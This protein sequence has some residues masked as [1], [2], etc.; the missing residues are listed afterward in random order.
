MT[1]L[2]IRPED[3]LRR[4][5]LPADLFARENAKIEVEAYFR[6]WRG[7]D[8]EAGNVVLPLRL[9]Q[10][11]STE[12]FH[13]LIFAALCSPNLSVAVRRISEY[14]RLVAPMHVIVDEDD[15]QLF[16]GIDWDDLAGDPP[17]SLDM[18]ELVFQ[19]QIARI[20]T[21]EHLVPL[22]VE[23]RHPIEHAQE[24]EEFFG[25]APVHGTRH[26]VTFSAADAQRP[27]L[28]ASESM[29]QTFAPE[30]QRRL[31]TLEAEAPLAAR[32]RSQLLESLPSGEA[33]VEVVARRLGLS[34]RTLQRRLTN[35]G[36]SFKEIVR[37]T[38][39]RL[40]RHYVANTKLGYAEIAFLIGFEE[41][42]SFFRAFHDW[43]GQTPRQMRRATVH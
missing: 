11:V 17:A 27:F 19:T 39:E 38:R 28:T 18:T 21:R 37:H 6:L 32:V 14:K 13:P 31:T 1:D 41:P 16:V 34:A 9:G 3:V 29:W 35:E 25:V 4:A 43:T 15:D 23:S 40:A 30:L 12:A 10:S 20:G 8:A 22:L 24:Y 42:S 36:A 7:L 5:D 2:G 26:G 33:S